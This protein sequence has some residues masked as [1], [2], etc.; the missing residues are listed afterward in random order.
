MYVDNYVLR[1][2][3]ETLSLQTTYLKNIYHRCLC[4]IFHQVTMAEKQKLIGP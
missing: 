4:W 1:K 3:N 2:T